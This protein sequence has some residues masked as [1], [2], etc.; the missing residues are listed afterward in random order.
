MVNEKDKVK[1]FLKKYEMDY[2]G[3][4]IDKSCETFIEDM[5]N[6]LEGNESSLK[7]IPTYIT[8]DKEIPLEEPV[9]AID[10]GGTN[11]RVAVVYFDKDK[12]PVIQDFKVYPM[13]GTK[14]EVS[15]EEFYTT[16]AQY[17]RPV[18][19]RSDKIGFCFSYPTEIL[20]NKDGK[21]LQLSKEV[22]L[23]DLV[24]D[25]IGENLLKTIKKM[26]FK[27]DK[28]IVMLND[29]VATLL[30]G[31]AS[32][33]DRLFDSYIGFIL[34]TGTNT[35]YIEENCNVKKV[36]D[37]ASK[38]GSMIIN[39][40]SGGYGKVKRGLID[41]EFDRET[42][43]PGVYSF[44]KM[45]SGRY[46]GGLITMAIKRAVK[47][48]L[49]SEQFTDNFNKVRGIALPEVNE[50]LNYPY[51]NNKLAMCCSTKNSG[52]NSDDH[53]VLYYLIDSLIERA[54]KL[55]TINLASIMIKTGKG[56]NPCKPVCITAEGSTFY[57]LKP[58]RS[59][60][61]YYVKEYMNE[62]KGLYCE[63]TKL[64]NVTLIGTTIAGL[65]N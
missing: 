57:K 64:E 50:F 18:L 7:M 37:L 65:I 6:G 17:I 43:D 38:E 21:L 11:F 12:K 54:A 9:I 3:I 29:T 40:E 34:G 4:D 42:V 5:K 22:Q 56:K 48:G 63:F 60:L 28:K 2:E 24:G 39:I 41:L 16:I 10:A 27:G 30:G 19:D 51:A 33:P 20:P 52:D 58:F 15:K 35:C 55:V 8:I 26:G 25:V 49:F 62:Q 14:G 23:K 47:D 44:E 59:K 31:K 32:Y 13:P 1:D 46:Q 53:L 61:E 45:V 36:A